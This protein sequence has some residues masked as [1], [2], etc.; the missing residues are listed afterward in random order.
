[1]D[2]NL[3][4]MIIVVGL[5]VIA[6]LAFFTWVLW[7]DLIAAH[8]WSQRKKYADD[9]AKIYKDISVSKKSKFGS[10]IKGKNS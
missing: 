8:K 1:M 9:V 7:D 2:K 5:I 10:N 3:T 6:S 4:T